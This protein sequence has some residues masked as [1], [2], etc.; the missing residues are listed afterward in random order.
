MVFINLSEVPQADYSDIF[1]TNLLCPSPGKV[2]SSASKYG[3]IPKHHAVF[4]C[5]GLSGGAAR[6]FQPQENIFRLHFYQIQGKIFLRHRTMQ[7][8]PIENFLL[9]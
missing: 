3:N 9:R 2:W 8:N 4:S 6:S 5:H 7:H 1:Y